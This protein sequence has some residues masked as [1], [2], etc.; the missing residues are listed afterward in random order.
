MQPIPAPTSQ[1]AADPLEAAEAT[2]PPA[3]IYE[4]AGP[5][6]EPRRPPTSS[7]KLDSAGF[8]GSDRDSAGAL[9]SAIA[10]EASQL[11]GLSL[12]LVALS[13]ADLFVTFSLL[14]TSHVFYESNPVAQW[15]FARWNMAGMTLFKFAVVGFVIALGEIIERRRPGWGRFVL[16]VGCAAAAAVVWHGLRLYLGAGG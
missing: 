16:L 14:R 8:G 6:I 2:D 4:L 12:C 10:L 1:H 9:L 11:Q 5:P 15:F 7:P 3:S 13:A